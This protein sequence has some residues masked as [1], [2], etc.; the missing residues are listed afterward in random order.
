[1]GDIKKSI[2]ELLKDSL[3]NDGQKSDVSV[4]TGNVGGDVTIVS[5][6]KIQISPGIAHISDQQAVYVKN[7]VHEVAR[8]ERVYGH[9]KATVPMV[10]NK[11]KA[12]LNVSSYRLIPKESYAEAISFLTDWLCQI[13]EDRFRDVDTLEERAE[14][15]RQCHRIAK[16]YSLYEEMRMLME[17]KWDAQSMRDLDDKA[18]QELK[19][20]MKALEAEYKKA[21]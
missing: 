1:M 5:R 6:A 13:N 9:K 14:T 19:A 21:R 15:Y 4:V 2:Q 18:L 11:L 7:M 12:A 3:T 20:F 17:R 8:M 16:R 10:W